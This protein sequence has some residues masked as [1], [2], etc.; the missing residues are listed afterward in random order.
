MKTLMN[1]KEIVLL[2]VLQAFDDPVTPKVMS[3]LDENG[4]MQTPVLHDMYPFLKAEEMKK[5]MFED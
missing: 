3:R 4:N 5:L 2:E 1:S